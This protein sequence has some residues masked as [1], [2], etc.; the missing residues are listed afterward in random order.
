MDGEDTEPEYLEEDRHLM[1]VFKLC[2]PENS[3]R[4]DVGHLENLAKF[5]VDDLQVS[6]FIDLLIILNVECEMG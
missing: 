1:M 5:Y 6:T 4:V 2:D 3:G